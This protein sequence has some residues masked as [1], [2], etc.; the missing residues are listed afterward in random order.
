MILLKSFKNIFFV[1]ELRKKLLFTLGVLIVYRIGMVIPI[2]GVDISA[3]GNLLQQ[4]GALGGLL[5]HIDLMSGGALSQCTIFALGIGPYIS[6]SIMMQL[7][8]MA[9]P[10]FEQLL[11]EGEYGRR[12]IN[13]YTRY[14]AVGLSLFWGS[15]YALWLE[16]SGMILSPG[17]GF[18]FLFVLSIMV[19]SLLVM[20]LADQISLFG[21]GSGSSIIIFAGIVA[22]FPSYISKSMQFISLG[23]LDPIVALLVLAIFI[24]ITAAIVFLERG[25]RKIPV[26]Y[27]R[28]VVGNRVYGGQSTHIP[29]KIN[30]PGVMPVIFAQTILMIP[31]QISALLSDRLPWLRVFTDRIGIAY[32]IIEACLIIFFSYFYTR[33]IFN[34]EQLADDM[35]KNGGF[36]LGLRPGRKT[37]EYFNYLLDR[38]GMVGALYLS[39]LA[40]F[41]TLLHKMITLPFFLPGTSLLIAVGVALDTAAQIESYL[42]ESRYEGFLVTGKLT[43]RRVR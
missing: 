2:I 26:Q 29:F 6:A 20:W 33:V 1:A 38:I 5:S 23:N 12:R 21:I 37:A 42:L 3:L 31:M 30:M 16:R 25:E 32:L 7:L 34:P 14:L 17:W 8:G 24:A 39:F 43:G 18:R 28:R 11:K 4:A 10:Y 9:V 40:I 19:G 13:Q 22:R 41:P 15:A 27:A 35:K 36:V